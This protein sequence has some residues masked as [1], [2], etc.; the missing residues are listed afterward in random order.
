MEA[1]FSCGWSFVFQWIT[2][3]QDGKEGYLW[4]K[5]KQIK[6]FWLNKSYEP[7]LHLF[8]LAAPC[9]L[10]VSLNRI[11]YFQLPALHHILTTMAR[12]LLGKGWDAK[13][14]V[15]HHHEV[16]GALVLHFPPLVI[17]SVPAVKLLL[18]SFSLRSSSI[19]HKPA[20]I[21]SYLLLH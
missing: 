1:L 9:Y 3:P 5:K 8:S 6:K 17:V 4:R 11:L 16:C 13:G 15:T 19:C 20:K 12:S 18:F 10:V 21:S 7:E 2:E 14:T